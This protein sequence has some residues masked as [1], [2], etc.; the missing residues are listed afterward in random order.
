MN[1]KPNKLLNI[2]IKLEEYNGCIVPIIYSDDTN[3]LN[4]LDSVLRN[5]GV[6]LIYNTNSL[7]IY[8]KLYSKEEMKSMKVE[9]FHPGYSIST[10][11]NTFPWLK[12]FINKSNYE[13]MK[14]FLSCED[15]ID[16]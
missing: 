13:E 7:L 3:T 14:L 9:S 12:E 16:I 15:Y 10:F 8:T 5:N 1:I 11:F 6:E 4:E 2:S